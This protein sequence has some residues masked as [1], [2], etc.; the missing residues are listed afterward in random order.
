MRRPWWGPVPNDDQR[1]VLDLVDDLVEDR[2]ERADDDPDAV[3]VAR[4]VLVEHG[5]WTLGAD[6]A[7]G[8]GGADQRTTLLAL[9][10]L[11]GTWPALAWASVQAHAACLLLADGGVEGGDLLAGV[12]QGQ[13]LAVADATDGQVEVAEG[14]VSGLL[15]RVD[16]S[17]TDAR[18]LALVDRETAV[19]LP[20]DAVR[21][22]PVL[23]RTG[24]GGALSH[25]CSVQGALPEGA[26]IHGPVVERARTLLFAGAAALAA[27]AAEAA[28][29]AAVSYSG[30]R[31]QF[32]GPLT[33]LPTVR[34]SLSTNV[35]AVRRLLVTALAAD[36]D[37]LVATAAALAPA[38]DDAIA[39]AAAAVQSHGGYGYMVEY[40]VE[41]LL[42]DLVSLR[43]ASGATEAARW[44]ADALVEAGA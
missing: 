9:A 5:L 21:H 25:P 20:S 38:L 30:E 28:A 35:T 10:R 14:R 13:P 7:T 33:D 44:A 29:H 16:A 4:R 23:R 40:R 11:A 6:E 31:E 18:V 2:L 37:D 27:G 1:A 19:L 41:G 24:L 15:T 3:A 42:R 12:H 39:V 43:A 36:A 8:G 17:A 32:G 26:V 34:T 22:G